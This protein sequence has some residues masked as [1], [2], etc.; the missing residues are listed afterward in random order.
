MVAT[1]F[2]TRGAEF[3]YDVYQATE[4]LQGLFVG[5]PSCASARGGFNQV[6]CAAK[7][8]NNALVGIRFIPANG[9]FNSGFQNLGEKIVGEPSCANSGSGYVTCAAKN[10]NN[11]LIG[12]RFDPTSGY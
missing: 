9:G 11:A 1:R 7:D 12:I 5:N 8:V 6:I 2:T 3:P 4:E 10:A